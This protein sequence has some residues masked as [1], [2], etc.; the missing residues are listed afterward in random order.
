[1]FSVVL[2]YYTTI[3]AKAPVAIICIDLFIIAIIVTAN[4][5]IPFQLY[6]LIIFVNYINS[7]NNSLRNIMHYMNS[8]LQEVPY[9]CLLYLLLTVIFSSTFCFSIFSIIALIICFI[10]AFFF[11]SEGLYIEISYNGIPPN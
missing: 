11:W 9:L 4:F 7:S 6:F 8:Y 2:I 10:V 3:C 5:S 1:M